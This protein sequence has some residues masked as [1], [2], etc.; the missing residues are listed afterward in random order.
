MFDVRT[1]NLKSK[2]ELAAEMKSSVFTTSV[3]HSLSF[4][5]SERSE[6]I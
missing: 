5:L 6:L 2:V 1:K 3:L 4:N